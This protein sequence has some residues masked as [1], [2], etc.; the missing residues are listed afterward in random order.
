[1]TITGTGGRETGLERGEPDQ[2]QHD[3]P[4]DV[5]AV[6]TAGLL[7]RRDAWDELGGL[8]PLL[9]LFGDDLDMGW[10]AARAG[11]RTRV[12]P[13]A[14]VFHAEAATRGL[15]PIGVSGMRVSALRRR[16]ALLVLL[17]NARTR[18]VVW[19]AMRLL[20]GSLL[21]AVGV[22]VAK[23][24]RE[25]LDELRAVGSVYG[26]P[27]RLLQ[28]SSPSPRAHSRPPEVVRRL[29][30]SPLLPYRHGLDTL[31]HVAVSVFGSG[32]TRP[33]GRRAG[34]ERPGRRR[35]SGAREL[36]EPAVPHHHAAAGLVARRFSVVPRLWLG[37]DLLGPGQLQGGA[38]VP[39][40]DAVG[41]WWALNLQA[42]HPVGDR[43]AS[44]RRRRTCSSWPSAARSPSGSRGCW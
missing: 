10:R 32:S 33:T 1:V 21:R 13:D 42:W 24:P 28:R 6:N 38:L 34:G 31:A 26:R 30:P 17:A 16:A 39:A 14:V 43:A 41:A 19:Q 22:P 20:A 3:E 23:A 37:R 5:L 18:A 40:P 8:E 12:A 36:T 35:G 11:Y 27:W 7:V 25:A 15:R 2:G 9:P 44:R 29:L 4:R